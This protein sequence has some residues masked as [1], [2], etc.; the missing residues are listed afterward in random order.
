[1]LSLLLHGGRDVEPA[2][3]QWQ[4]FRA[5]C[6]V[7]AEMLILLLHGGRDI[8]PASTWRQGC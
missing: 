8:E 3:T 4:R 1:M 2:A 6:C 7:V 5:C